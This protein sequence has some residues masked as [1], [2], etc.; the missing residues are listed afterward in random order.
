MGKSRMILDAMHSVAAEGV[1]MCEVHPN[2]E[3]LRI[4]LGEAINFDYDE[5]LNFSIFKR[6][7][8]RDGGPFSDIERALKMLETVALELV[9]KRQKPLVLVF[10][11]IHHFKNNDAGN[12]MLLLLQ[13][14]AEAW[15]T[16]GMLFSYMQTINS[17]TASFVRHHK[18]C[19]HYAS[20]IVIEEIF[21]S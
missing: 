8:S 7:T 16:S 2:L 4:R 17:S 14:K 12:D 10:N 21:K 15:A 19:F 5:D 11:N 18:Y 9:D 20:T 6:R 3:V 1:A 13:Q